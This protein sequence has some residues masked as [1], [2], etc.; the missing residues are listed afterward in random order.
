MAT[1]TLP[2][3]DIRGY[4]DQ[5]GIQLPATRGSEA[6]VRCFAHAAAHRREDR[7]P[8]CSVNTISGAWLCHGCGARGGAYDAALAKGHTPRSAIDLMVI[9]GLIERCA[10]LRSARELLHASSRPSPLRA[11]APA[12]TDPTG[13]RPSLRLTDEDISRW[14]ASLSHRPLLIARLCAT[15]SW[16]YETMCA[17]GLGLDRGRITIPIRNAH[18]TLR[19]LLRYQPDSTSGPKMLAA[20][21]TRLGLVPH[22]AFESSERILLVEGPPDMIAAR[23][24]GV[25]A[26]AVPGDHAWQTSWARF[27]TGRSITIVMD[28]DEQGRAAAKRIARD[29]SD[30]A[31]PRIV[32]IAP[33]RADGYDLTDW[34]LDA[35]FSGSEALG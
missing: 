17:L 20:S 22:P 8:S 2:G 21:G 26:L 14:Q 33:H 6:S 27:L 29:L 32:D 19:G 4:Y 3:A 12:T 25:P 15:R 34:L 23:S 24:H 9:H 30:V 7:D 5:L 13:A 31:E 16:R 1:L 11:H 10:R 35:G 28:A 18:G